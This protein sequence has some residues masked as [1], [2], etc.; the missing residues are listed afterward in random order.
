MKPTKTETKKMKKSET[1]VFFPF[2][3]RISSSSSCYLLLSLSLK[4]Y[5]TF[6]VSEVEDWILLKRYHIK[7][8]SIYYSSQHFCSE[9][10]MLLCDRCSLDGFLLLLGTTVNPP[11]PSITFTVQGFVP[12][13]N[14]HQAS[15]PFPRI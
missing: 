13:Y 14:I 2:K 7:C 3:M 6:F 12:S 8:N 10:E 9:K 5:G 15:L 1:V 11:L 4:K